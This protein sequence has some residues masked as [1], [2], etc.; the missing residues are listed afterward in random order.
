MDDLK[1]YSVSDNYITFLRKYVSGVYSNKEG[2]RA[3]TRK[4]LGVVYTINGY[5]YYIP[6]SS[7]KD[8]DYSS[9]LLTKLK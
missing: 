3:H 2:M 5:N 7:P 8:S 1:I 6:L 4:Y 9:R